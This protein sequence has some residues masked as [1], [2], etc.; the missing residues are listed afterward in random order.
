MAGAQE[1]GSYYW[2]L[3]EAVWLPLNL[4]WDDGPEGFL[5]QF[6]MVQPRVGHLYAAHWCQSE[7]RNGGFY[8]FFWNTTGL[9]APEA[10]DGFRAVGITEWSAI[11]AEA[12]EFFGHPYPR[13]RAARQKLLPGHNGK[14]SGR[15]PF[16]A[17]NERFYAWLRAE[18]DPW[19]CAADQ[20]AETGHP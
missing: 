20:Y 14:H 17:L 2:L 5:R 4:S 16:D 18:P 12:M 7:V 1:P 13:E 15:Y 6:R 19:H 11:L 10:L 9:L 8:Q 3:V